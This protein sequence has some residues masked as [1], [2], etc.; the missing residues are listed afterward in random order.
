MHNNPTENGCIRQIWVLMQSLEGKGAHH[1]SQ[2]SGLLCMMEPQGKLSQGF[3]EGVECSSPHSTFWEVMQWR[4]IALPLNLLNDACELIG[5]SY[6]FM[7][8]SNSATLS[9]ITFIIGQFFNMYSGMVMFF[10]RYIYLQL[11]SHNLYVICMF[12]KKI[13]FGLERWL[14]SWEHWLLFLR[15]W[16]Q[17][18]GSTWWLTT[19]CNEIRCPLL[20]CLKTA[21]SVL[22][23]NK[24]INLF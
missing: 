3:V 8:K 2:P 22:T 5:H 19:I 11:F 13:I 21:T 23:N 16:V 15:S 6:I 4:P 9:H 10:L 17:I 1:W 20:V 18:P 14:S 12:I 7:F 24:Y